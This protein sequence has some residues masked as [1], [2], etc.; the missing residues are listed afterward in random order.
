[1]HQIW[2]KTWST[3]FFSNIISPKGSNKLFQYKYNFLTII[4][5]GRLFFRFLIKMYESNASV[6]C[7]FNWYFF[8][9]PSTSISTKHFHAQLHIIIIIMS[10]MRPYFMTY[11]RA[12]LIINTRHSV[13][14]C[15]CQNNPENIQERWGFPQ[16]YS[17]RLILSRFRHLCSG[18]I[19]IVTKQTPLFPLGNQEVTSGV[20]PLI[21][22]APHSLIF[23]CSSDG[24]RE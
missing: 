7:C 6:R 15:S 20:I 22:T 13:T 9:I 10:A 8:T 18:G 23:I 4:S 2:Y 1:M 21:T 17:Q 14:H 3:R 16:R 5:Y 24:L 19:I 11:K 12:L